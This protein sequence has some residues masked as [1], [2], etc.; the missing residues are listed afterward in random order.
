MNKNK[1]LTLIILSVL[2]FGGAAFAQETAEPDPG[3][4]PDSSFYFLD[5]IGEK[6]SL[7]FT[8]KVENKAEKA[9]RFA[10]EKFAEAKKM[11]EENRV[12]ALEKADEKY[13]HFLS[14][15]NQ[16]V[17]EAKNKGKDVEEL[18]IRITENALRHR[19]VLTRVLENAPE[20]AKDEIENAIEMSQNGFESAIQSVLGEKKEELM[21][22][23]D[24]MRAV[25]TV[26]LETGPPQISSPGEGE[27]VRQQ[28]IIVTPERVRA[29][30]E[31]KEMIFYYL[32]TCGHCQRVKSDGIVEKLEELGIKVT[33]V[34]A[35]VGPI[36]HEFQG[37]PT[38]VIGEKV[39]VGYRTFD[40]L[41]EL[42]LCE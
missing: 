4:T 25:S 29:E 34:D 20:E 3:L 33:Q 35:R 28:E 31:F 39:Y 19:E 8:F 11:A 14:L 13:Q 5:T 6:I 36:K 41:K 1:I 9:L 22:R 7:F 30:C 21:E 10:E 16:R 12:K 18:A 2:L 23:N 24:Y 32:D 37:V 15:A 42:L 38:F 26:R 27:G 17:R 40:S